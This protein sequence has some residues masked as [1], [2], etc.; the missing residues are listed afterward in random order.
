MIVKLT[1]QQ[2]ENLEYLLDK[3]KQN[4]KKDFP[5][6]PEIQRNWKKKYETLEKTFDKAMKRNC[7]RDPRA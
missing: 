4:I 2:I 6:D 1:W 3:A 5:N 7:F